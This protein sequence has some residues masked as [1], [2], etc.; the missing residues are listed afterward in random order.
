MD[1]ATQ[2]DPFRRF[3]GAPLIPLDLVPVGAE[4]RYELPF[5]AGQVAP[6]PLDRASISQLFQDALGLS[7]WK[8]PATRAGR[9]A[10]TRPVEIFIRPKAI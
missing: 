4:P 2:P 8:Q 10:S 3:T 7:A 1:W 5:L 9:Y 6:S